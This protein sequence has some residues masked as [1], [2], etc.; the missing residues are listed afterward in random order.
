MNAYTL[1]FR[2][3]APGRRGVSYIYAEGGDISSTVETTIIQL[4]R[5]E[6]LSNVKAL[7]VC[8]HNE[9]GSMQPCKNGVL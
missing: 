7:S 2:W 8:Q 1:K 4:K 6:K 3:D 5:R 9:C